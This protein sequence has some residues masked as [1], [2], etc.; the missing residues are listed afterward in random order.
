VII[1][2]VLT[3]N[4]YSG[5]LTYLTCKVGFSLIYFLAQ[6]KKM[7]FF[8]FK[9]ELLLK[10]DWPNRKICNNNGKFCQKLYL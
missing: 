4:N 5:F 10:N 3:T 7:F 1:F 9:A 6:L 8:I 2:F